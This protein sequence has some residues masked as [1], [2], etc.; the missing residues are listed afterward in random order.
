MYGKDEGG[1]GRLWAQ[2]GAVRVRLSGGKGLW[3]SG[4]DMNWACP[5]SCERAVCML[6]GPVAHPRGLS[7]LIGWHPESVAAWYVSMALGIGCQGA[8]KWIVPQ[9]VMLNAARCQ[10]D[11]DDWHTLAWHAGFW[12]MC[13]AYV[14]T[15]KL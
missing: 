9:V 6:T 15:L 13:W 7:A 5:R 1:G 12:R 3:A 14:C 11:G 10:D 4:K 2:V 8:A